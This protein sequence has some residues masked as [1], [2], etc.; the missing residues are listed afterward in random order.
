MVPAAS[1]GSPTSGFGG[2]EEGLDDKLLDLLYESPLVFD[3][4]SSFQGGA[5]AT[6]AAAVGASAVAPAM[7]Q[8]LAGA[9]GIKAS[10]SSSR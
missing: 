3:G 6:G 7:P 10:A 9:A 2:G 1:M 8:P 5:A 4:V